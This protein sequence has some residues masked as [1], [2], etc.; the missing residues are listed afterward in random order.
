MVAQ[1]TLSD[2]ALFHR[3]PNPV[4]LRRQDMKAKENAKELKVA[5]ASMAKA[6]KA[7]KVE[8][9]PSTVGLARRLDIGLMRAGSL[10][11]T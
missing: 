8:P 4:D 7:G 11:R 9:H 5:K 10:I 3:S 2:S 1:A 6:E